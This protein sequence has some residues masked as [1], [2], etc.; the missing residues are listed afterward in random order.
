MSAP[1][2]YNGMIKKILLYGELSANEIKKYAFV[3]G[4]SFRPARPADN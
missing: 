4:L 1:F 2:Y 3:Q